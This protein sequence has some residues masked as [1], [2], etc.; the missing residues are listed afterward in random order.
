MGNSGVKNGTSENI[1]K[2]AIKNFAV[3]SRNKLIKDIKNKAAMIGI[4]ERGIQEPLSSSTGNIQLFDI[5]MQEPYRIEGKA[6]EQRNALIQEL[7]SR[8]K[9]AIYETAYGTLVEEVA[10]TWF[11]RIIAIRFME[12]NNYM[13]DRLRVLSSGVEGINEPEFITHVFE[14]RF[15]FSE[16]ERN[17]I[18]DLKSDGNSLAMDELFQFLFIKQCNGLNANLPELFEKTNDYTELLLSVSYND[19]EGVIY[20]LVHTVPEA[21]FDVKSDDGN[22]Q[23]EIIGWLYQYYNTEPKAAVFGRPKSKK[24]EKQDIPAATQLFTP[25]WV[26][27]YM[28]ENSLGRLWIEKLLA[29][30]DIRSEKQIAKDFRWRYYIPEVEQDGISEIQLKEQ[31]RGRG[32]L[33]VEDITFLDPAMGSFHIGIYA[34]EVFLQLYEDEGY[35]IQ[36]ATQLI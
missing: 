2:T 22:G 21:D 17:R 8:E 14:T 15:E 7:K 31:L 28:V 19:I 23:I 34:F 6:I 35:T 20:K 18:I 33:S 11:N 10:Y 27:K 4:T 29:N 1:N 13:P 36:E 26:V 16:E 3:Y 24:I 30:G 9:D 25:E 32:N 12:V 5:G